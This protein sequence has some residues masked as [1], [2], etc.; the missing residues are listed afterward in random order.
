MIAS[1][2]WKSETEKVS[3]FGE[4]KDRPQIDSE[5]PFSLWYKT[6]RNLI[7]IYIQVLCARLKPS[8]SWT[9]PAAKDKIKFIAFSGRRLCRS[10]VAAEAEIIERRGE[11]HREA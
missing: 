1:G 2:K 8:E 11:K 7:I 10:D 4:S 6:T 5:F 9:E 3:P